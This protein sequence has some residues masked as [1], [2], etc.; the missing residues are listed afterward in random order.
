MK[1]IGKSGRSKLGRELS[2]CYARLRYVV[3]TG[4]SLVTFKVKRKQG[5][6]QRKKAYSLFA[7]YCY[8][9]RLAQDE[10]HEQADADAFGAHPRVYHDGLKVSSTQLRSDRGGVRMLMVQSS[11][12]IE[13]TTFCIRLPGTSATWGGKS[14]YSW[15][16]GNNNVPSL[17]K[18]APALLFFRARSSVGR[19][20]T[21]DQSGQS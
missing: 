5:F 11:D 8:S 19:Q 1:S 16:E 15:D 2:S 12:G 3:L 10:L 18:K 6:N 9:G 14:Y 21:G 20:R 7:S 17:S 4:G 13:D